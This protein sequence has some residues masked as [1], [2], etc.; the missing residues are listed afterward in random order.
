MLLQ[1]SWVYLCGGQDKTSR[2]ETEWRKLLRPKWGG[3]RRCPFLLITNGNDWLD[4]Y[5]IDKQLHDVRKVTMH[6]VCNWQGDARQERRKEGRKVTDLEML[7]EGC[8]LDAKT[9]PLMMWCMLRSEFSRWRR[10]MCEEANLVNRYLT[11]RWSDREWWPPH[12]TEFLDSYARLRLLYPQ[13]FGDDVW[14]ASTEDVQL[15][16][17]GEG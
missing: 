9:F 8:P 15:M 16:Q 7:R 17:E 1:R 11:G 10:L 6:C 12:L 2:V 13:C 4:S 14:P 3:K 5:K